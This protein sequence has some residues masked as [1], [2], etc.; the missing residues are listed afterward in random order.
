MIECSQV[1]A[2]IA[3]NDS[4]DEASLLEHVEGCEDCRHQV[5]ADRELTDLVR[6]YPRFDLS[7]HFNRNLKT[8]LLEEK[9][10]QRHNKRRGL[11]M[12]GYW[13]ASSIAIAVVMAFIQW[14]AQIPSLPVLSVLGLFFGV[15][16]GIPLIFCH[17][18]RIGPLEL[19]YETLAQF[20]NSPVTPPRAR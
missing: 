5:Q 15:M 13:L 8:R 6:G 10:L 20:R 14:P 7:I 17:S 3:A 9:Q 2:L 1:Q 11:I 19:V 18:M 16:V 12:G 4:V